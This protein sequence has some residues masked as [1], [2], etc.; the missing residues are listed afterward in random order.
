MVIN[1][2]L[3]E[4]QHISFYTMSVTAASCDK[5]IG[6]VP[7]DEI[8]DISGLQDFKITLVNGHGQAEIIDFVTRK[9]IL[10]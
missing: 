6:D 2:K 4:V 7:E 10:A 8:F 3:Y 9:H 5:S 1:D